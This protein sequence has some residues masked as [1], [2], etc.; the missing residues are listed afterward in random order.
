MVALRAYER[1]AATAMLR[2]ARRR[3]IDEG[4]HNH[5]GSQGLFPVVFM[6]G[7]LVPFSILWP[8]L[9]GFVT[10]LF[11]ALRGQA[12]AGALVVEIIK[13]SGTAR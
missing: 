6:Y 2:A 11:A 12:P 9:F 10:R 8:V 13:V 5:V 1:Q 4:H 3:E 7:A